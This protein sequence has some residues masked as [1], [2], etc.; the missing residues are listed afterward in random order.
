[1]LNPNNFSSIPL[2]NDPGRS[3][4][5]FDCV[6]KGNFANSPINF[7]EKNSPVFVALT[8]NPETESVLVGRP[9]L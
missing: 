2:T 9:V 6:L 5:M 1:M 8:Q 7:L 3:Q 4:P